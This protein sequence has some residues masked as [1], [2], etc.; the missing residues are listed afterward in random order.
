M[1]ARESIS[2]SPPEFN[3]A[4]EA[5]RSVSLRSEIEVT[6]IP[7]PG[8][9]AP[10]AVA[11]SADVM[12]PKNFEQVTGEQLDELAT[13][14]IVLL[15]DPSCP[16]EWG[17]NF[18]VVSYVRAELEHELGHDSLIGSVAWS[19]L[20]EAL[21]GNDAAYTAEGGTVTRVLS[22]SFGSLASRPTSVDL[23]IRASWTPD[24]VPGAMG[25]HLEAWG[26]LICMV[27][28]LPPVP[29]GVTALPGRRR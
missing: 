13:G 23:E 1:N 24:D 8:R 15:Y 10:Y 5:L 9:L 7:P 19:W 17:G 16:V 28:G 20:V 29:E 11:M 4:C 3:E 22:E 27:A 2:A 12:A 6:E 21:D 14:R 25:R 26:E 18:R